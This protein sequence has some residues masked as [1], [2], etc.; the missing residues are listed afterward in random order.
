MPVIELTPGVQIGAD[1]GEPTVCIPVYE[2]YDLFTQCLAS[3]LAH[4]DPDVA[5]LIFDDASPDPALRTLL[6]D[7]VDNGAWSHSLYYARQPENVG[8]VHNLND[9]TA[10]AKPADVVIVNSDCIVTE[11]WLPGLRNAAYSESRIATATA[12]TNAGTIVSVPERNR[13][14]GALPRG[15]T[16]AGLAASIRGGSLRTHPDLPTCVAHCVY[17]R[18]SALDLVGPLDTV[19]SPAYEEEVVLSQRCVIH[20]LRHVVADDVF[21]FHKEAGSFG[22][23]HAITSVREEHHRIIAARYPYYD[24]WI[25]EVQDDRY[26]SLAQTVARVRTAFRA[27]SVTID[28]RCLTPSM[29]GTALATLELISALDIHTELALRVVLP[30]E[31]DEYASGIL[32]GR[33]RIEILPHHLLADAPVVPTDIAHRPY[34]VTSAED[35]VLLQRLGSRVVITQQDNIAFRNPAYFKDYD[36]WLQYRSVAT[37]ALATADQVVFVSR[38][39]AEDARVLGLVCEEQVNVVHEGTDQTLTHLYPEQ[40]P[41]ENAVQLAQGG[42]LLCLGTDFLHKNRVFALR[43]FEALSTGEAF[44]GW[45]VFAG[46]KAA[47]GSSAG[48]EAAYLMARPELAR[49]V[50]D[51]GAVAETEKQWLLREAAAVLYPTVYE[52]F[53]LVPFEAA[54]VGTPCVF[55]WNTSLAELIPKS[56][57]LIVPWDAEETAKNV[58]KLLDAG[59]ERERVVKAVQMSGARLTA[60]TNAR[61]HLEV[62][63][64]ALAGSVPS[65][66]RVA[67]E[68]LRLRRQLDQVTAELREFTD[69]PLNR[70]LVGRDAILPPELRRPVL[71][72]AS[73]RTLRRIVKLLYRSGYALRHG[74]RAPKS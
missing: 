20:G 64:R 4:T 53:G 7:A 49:R 52:G 40:S 46:P 34:Q 68:T 32:A 13:S 9:A 48:E 18:R 54:R 38:H 25:S 6:Q 12:L 2:A 65:A 21:V 30:D 5:I 51:L 73:R 62:Y 8:F 66:A 23:E 63:Q 1:R 28:G 56:A 10:S 44:N 16:L 37:A 61:R 60:A 15:V 33:N 74:K 43:L 59:A 27:M 31:V 41:P 42:F 36:E 50:L 67:H 26:S 69:D 29:T 70:G 71:A 24:D 19:F 47:W 57:A 72:V 55:A 35:S 39:G 14:I 22:T 45:L 17:V 58:A 11:G 3:V